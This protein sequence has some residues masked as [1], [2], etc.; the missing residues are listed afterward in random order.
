MT[1]A[2]VTTSIRQTRQV[3]I[4]QAAFILGLSRRTVERRLANGAL[5]GV[6]VG[7]KWLVDVPVTD[8]DTSQE[9][10][11]HNSDGQ[12][13]GEIDIDILRVQLA[14]MSQKIADLSHERDSLLRQVSDLTTDKEY[15][16]NQLTLMAR[17]AEQAMQARDNAESEWRRLLNNEQQNTI[18]IG[19]QLDRLIKLLPPPREDIIEGTTAEPQ[20]KRVE[21][22][23]RPWWA[24]WR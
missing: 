9:S 5:S 4:D 21:P 24:F 6:K 10:N 16:K 22:Q 13:T 17:Q 23:Q 18:Q 3:T 14:D 20:L 15:L 7:Q 12:P 2:S 1:E 11:R 8:N 19:S